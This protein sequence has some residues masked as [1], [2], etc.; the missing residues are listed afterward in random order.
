VAAEVAATVAPTVDLITVL[1][2][3]AMVVVAEALSLQAQ[4]KLEVPA[5]TVL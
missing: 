2:L 4:A 3:Q 5:A 1:M